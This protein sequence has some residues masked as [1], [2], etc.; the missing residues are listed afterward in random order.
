V[1][2]KENT[3]AIIVSFGVQGQLGANTSFRLTRGI[4]RLD[5]MIQLLKLNPSY[6]ECNMNL[7]PIANIK[8]K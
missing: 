3:V 6:I 8:L 2:K 7:F 4:I 5:I 1:G